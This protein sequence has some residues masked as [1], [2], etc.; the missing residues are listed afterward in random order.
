MALRRV[1]PPMPIRVQQQDARPAAFGD[2]ENRFE[3]SAAYG[4]W[5]SSGCW[6]S[7]GWDFEEWDVLAQRSNGVSMACLLVCDRACNQWRLEAYY[8]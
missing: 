7:G 5:K 3:I 2:G 8:D 6:W 1:R 4:P